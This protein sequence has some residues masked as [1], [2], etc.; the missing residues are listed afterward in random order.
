M[1]NPSPPEASERAE[2]SGRIVYLDQNIWIDLLKRITDAESDAIRLRE[3]LINLREQ[4]M[5]Q[6][7][8]SGSHYLE[9]WHRGGFESR[10][11]L[12]RL[13]RDIS[14]Y[15]TLA[16]VHVIEEAGV[17]AAIAARAGTEMPVFPPLLGRG[18]NHAFASSTGRF[19]VVGS[20]AS[21]GVDEGPPAAVP[22]IL[23]QAVE[24]GAPWEW[25]NLAGPREF[26]AGGLEV[27]PEHRKGNLVVADE[28]A[29]RMKIS[30]DAGMRARLED[31]IITEEMVR[32]ADYVNDACEQLGVDPIGL[33][34]PDGSGAIR[35]FVRS[36]PVA[37]VHCQLRVYRHS[38]LE[39]PI[40]QHDY[41]DMHTLAL[42]V[43]YCDVVV[44]ER[45][46]AH[47][48]RQTKLDRKYQTVP[49]SSLGQLASLLNLS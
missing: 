25:I 46:W 40:E 30:N 2:F 11:A 23:A 18:V 17:A 6:V 8:L 3:R 36:V 13:M 12:A 35:E 43:P 42:V 20:I 37:D 33:F 9:T 31:L 5:I 49:A 10:W 21:G 7:P 15:T 22:A 4:G 28:L 14:G 44:T 45:R 19:R 1:T 16:P 29:L 38:N 39:F 34:M 26:P 24:L 48:I 27:R 41:T 32:I 47:A